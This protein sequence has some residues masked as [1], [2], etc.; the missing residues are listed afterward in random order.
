ML[1]PG[2]SRRELF[3]P[4]ITSFSCNQLQIQDYC[5]FFLFGVSTMII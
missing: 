3:E 4:D 1:L 5:C 2:V